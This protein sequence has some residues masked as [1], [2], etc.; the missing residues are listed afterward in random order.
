MHNAN[1]NIGDLITRINNGSR[2]G[3][4]VIKAPYNKENYQVLNE[5]VKLGVV[6]NFYTLIPSKTS[7]SEITKSLNLNSVKRVLVIT[8]LSTRVRQGQEALQTISSPNDY[9][10]GVS[11]NP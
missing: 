7:N 5:L 11:V 8:L 10:E 1:Y 3:L 9:S 4:G 6:Q 2:A